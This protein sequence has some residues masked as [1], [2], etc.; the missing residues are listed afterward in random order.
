MFS[1]RDTYFHYTNRFQERQQSSLSTNANSALSKLLQNG[2]IE[3]SNSGNPNSTTT[4][5]AMEV[6]TASTGG[7]IL[8]NNNNAKRMKL[9]QDDEKQPF[10]P[11]VK[12]SSICLC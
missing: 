6:T 1:G 2:T 8:N 3:D 9:M 5:T 11:P 4:S 10:Q 7:S 12:V